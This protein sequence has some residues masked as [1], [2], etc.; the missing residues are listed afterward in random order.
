VVRKVPVARRPA[1]P[2]AH[3]PGVDRARAPTSRP[4][5]EAHGGGLVARGCSTR[6]AV[7]RCLASYRRSDD[8]RRRGRIPALRRARPVDQ[9]LDAH[10]L[11]LD[12]L[13]P[14]VPAYGA[15]RVEEVTPEKIERW[16]ATVSSADGSPLSNR[17]K[18][19]LLVL[20]HGVF[21]RAQEVYGLPA[22]RSR[23]SSAISNTRAAISR[24]SAS[25]RCTPSR[26][27]LTVPLSPTLLSVPRPPS[28]PA[29]GRV[30]RS[31]R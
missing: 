12:R 20:L 24:C 27:R 19:K 13:G 31:G 18:N 15:M 5:H 21:R 30:E 17:T 10:R 29:L 7:G 16:R 25:R 3:R 6:R 22:N 2:E 14:L 11:P 4:R 23:A 28:R 26:A 1:G 8:R 9:A